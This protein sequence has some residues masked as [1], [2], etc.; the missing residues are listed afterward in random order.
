MMQETAAKDITHQK[1]IILMIY[2]RSNY[3]HRGEAL[4]SI[5]SISMM[6][7]FKKIENNI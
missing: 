1:L 3:G 7:Y 6:N 5:A 4:A 2:L